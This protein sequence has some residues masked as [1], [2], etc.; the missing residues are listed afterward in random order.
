M[1]IKDGRIGR[2]SLCGS[3]AKNA[4]MMVIRTIEYGPVMYA[5]RSAMRVAALFLMTGLLC[6]CASMFPRDVVPKRLID[7]AELAGMPNVRVW[8]MLRLRRLP[9]CLRSN[10]SGGSRMPLMVVSANNRM[11]LTFS[12]YLAEATTVPSAPVSWSG[13]VML[14]RDLSSIWSPG[15]VPAR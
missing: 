6:G 7:E 11:S 10:K 15:S 12:Q 14:A 2:H 4:M 8:G 13:G 1:A 3:T 9:P 5:S